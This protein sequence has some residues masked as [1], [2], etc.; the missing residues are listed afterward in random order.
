[1]AFY[2]RSYYTLVKWAL[3]EFTYSKSVRWE[4]AGEWWDMP[5]QRLQAFFLQ[6]SFLMKEHQLKSHTLCQAI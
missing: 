1:M 6:Y 5:S 4:H 3:P 2:L